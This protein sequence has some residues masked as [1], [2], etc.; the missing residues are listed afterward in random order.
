MKAA[1]FIRQQNKDKFCWTREFETI[2]YIAL[3]G[4]NSL[5]DFK[6]LQNLRSFQNKSKLISKTFGNKR[7]KPNIVA[8]SIN[9]K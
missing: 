1:I 3:D 6:S 8:F 2:L 9:Y 7:L 5:K 4:W